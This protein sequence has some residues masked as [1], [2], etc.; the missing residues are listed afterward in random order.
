MTFK[1]GTYYI[2][3]PCYIFNKS[4]DQILEQTDYFLSE[5]VENIFGFNCL[6]GG[7]AYGDGTYFD[8]Y[9]RKYWVDAGLIG[10]LPVELLGIDKCYTKEQIETEEGMHI[11]TFESDF[12]AWVSNGHF[13]FGDININTNYDDE[14]DSDDDYDS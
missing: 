8:N 1:A 10:I 12:K 5:S 11:I 6:V 7:T 14:S 9:G 13:Y 4:W 2:G 3:D